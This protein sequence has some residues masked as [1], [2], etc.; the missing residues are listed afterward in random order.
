MN[1]TVVICIIVLLCVCLY[2]CYKEG[3]QSYEIRY[4]KFLGS[5]IPY[6]ERIDIDS[7]INYNPLKEPNTSSTV[8]RYIR[9]K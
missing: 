2:H 9:L 8:F 5:H 1:S 3:Y 6:R 4:N 7:N